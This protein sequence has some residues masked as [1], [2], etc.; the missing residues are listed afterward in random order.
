MVIYVVI[1][2][3]YVVI[4]VMYVVIMVIYVVIMVIYVGWKAQSVKPPL[5]AA[6]ERASA[7]PTAVAPRGGDSPRR[8]GP[9]LAP[10]LPSL[11]FTTPS[12]QNVLFSA[13]FRV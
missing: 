4:M 2:V 7:A 3:I 8:A 5:L 13:R 6:I 12:G 11:L 1:M 10:L 9:A